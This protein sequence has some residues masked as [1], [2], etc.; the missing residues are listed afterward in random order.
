MIT[1]KGPKEAKGS[2]VRV[3]LIAN[4]KKSCPVRAYKKLVSFWGH[5]KDWAIPLMSRSNGSLLT[6]R[7]FNKLLVPLSLGITEP[8]GK[9]ILSHSFHGVVPT[10]M[11][12]AGYSD[13]EIQRQGR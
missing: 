3:K 4:N 12:R 13:A 6:G 10:L 11:A 1:L 2:S 9:K 5:D 7:Y 8:E